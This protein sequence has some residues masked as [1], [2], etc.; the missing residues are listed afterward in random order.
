[1]R[2]SSQRSST[3]PLHSGMNITSGGPSPAAWYAICSPSRSAYRVSGM[4]AIPPVLSRRDQRCVASAFV[5][6]P[7]VLSGNTERIA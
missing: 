7:V 5:V 6:W 1:M 4:A 3:C 2:G